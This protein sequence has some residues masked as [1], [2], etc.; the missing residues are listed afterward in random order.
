MRQGLGKSGLL[1]RELWVLV[2]GIQVPFGLVVGRLRA[3]R[4]I[5]TMCSQR[6]RGRP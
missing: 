1:S 6:K 5:G 3:D 4:I 2:E